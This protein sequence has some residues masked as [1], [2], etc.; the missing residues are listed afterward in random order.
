MLLTTNQSIFKEEF[1]A[2]SYSFFLQTNLSFHFG[3]FHR[4]LIFVCFLFVFRIWFL[5]IL[6]FQNS[7][8][9]RFYTGGQVDWV[10]C[11]LVFLK[12]LFKKCLK[13]V[14]NY[15]FS[16]KFRDMSRNILNR[17][18][19]F[20]F[21]QFSSFVGARSLSWYRLGFL[22]LQLLKLKV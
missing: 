7:L 5:F 12:G 11:V 22:L 9:F 19:P 15:P 1:M 8:H 14:C 16:T 6:P 21:V 4:F 13:T 20:A 10:F 18:F 2:L 17:P 3:H